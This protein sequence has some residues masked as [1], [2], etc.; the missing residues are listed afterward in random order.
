[1]QSLSGLSPTGLKTIFY[2]PNF[3]DNSN[4]E[5]QVPVFPRNRVAQLYPQ[6]LDSLFVA[7]YDSESYGGGILTSLHTDTTTGQI[8]Y[9]YINVWDQAILKGDN[10]KTCSKFCN[11]ADI[12]IRHKWGWKF[13]L[14]I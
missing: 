14:Q 1:V 4:L 11:K 9:S 6:V 3:L 5:G 7:S 13:M 2:Y 10:S 12:D 8:I